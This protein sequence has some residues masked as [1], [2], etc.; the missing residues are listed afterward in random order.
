MS[1]PI[2]DGSEAINIPTDVDLEKHMG[3]FP[4]EFVYIRE[5]RDIIR[6]TLTTET[7]RIVFDGLIAGKNHREIAEELG[8]TAGRV[9]Q[10]VFQVRMSTIKLFKRLEDRDF[11]DRMEKTRT[12]AQAADFK[13][14]NGFL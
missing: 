10:I 14:R 1:K 7:K 6:S 11:S 3:A 8:V 9:G 5:M 12:P 2:V 13:R 4:E